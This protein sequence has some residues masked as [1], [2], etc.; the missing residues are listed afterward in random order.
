MR[1]P[2]EIRRAVLDAAWAVALERAMTPL[3]AATHRDV[4]ARLVP[5][6][7]ARHAVL[8]TWKNLVRAGHLQPRGEV[9]VPGAA[10]PLMA[11][12]PAADAPGQQA[13]GRDHLLQLQRA[14]AGAR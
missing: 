5:Q 11:C 2:G 1:P 6:G 9:R 8:N 4:V 14:W 3:P 7:V 12:A 10:R 13:P